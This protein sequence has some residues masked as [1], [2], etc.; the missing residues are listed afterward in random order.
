MARLI[1]RASSPGP[2]TDSTGAS[3]DVDGPRLSTGTEA[4]QTMKG[5]LLR[6]VKVV[7][8]ARAKRREIR[9]KMGSEEIG[10][11]KESIVRVLWLGQAVPGQVHRAP[12]GPGAPVCCRAELHGHVEPVHDRD[13]VVVYVA[14]RVEAV[15]GRGSRG[16]TVRPASEL[17]VAVPGQAAA[18]ARGVEGA[19]GAG[20]DLGGPRAVQEGDGPVVA[21][22]KAAAAAGDGGRPDGVGTVVG[23]VEDD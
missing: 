9:R 23:D 7:A 16:G 17:P 5:Q 6:T 21:G 14:E 8:C 2:Y 19:V 4:A 10:L 18:P 11:G 13:V 1:E 3:G 20:P 22:V 12:N 15:L